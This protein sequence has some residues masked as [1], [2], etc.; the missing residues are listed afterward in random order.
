MEKNSEIEYVEVFQYIYWEDEWKKKN[1]LKR[2]YTNKK[3][4][5]NG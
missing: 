4:S 5:V 3:E 1:H 2:I